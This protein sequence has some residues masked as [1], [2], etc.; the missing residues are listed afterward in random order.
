MKKNVLSVL[1]VAGIAL[2]A[3]AQ[4]RHD[5]AVY[6]KPPENKFWKHIKSSLDSFHN[7]KAQQE[8]KALQM[9]YSGVDIPKSINEFKIIEAAQ[10]VSQGVTGTCWCF[11]TTSFFDSEVYRLYHKRVQLSPLYT[12]YW[13][14]VEKAREYVKTRGASLFDEGSETNAVQ[15]MMKKYGIVT[16]QDYSGLQSGQPYQD[17]SKMV[18]EMKSYLASIKTQNAWNEEDVITT[19]E[20]IM[21]HY[22]GIPPATVN[23]DGKQYTPQQYLNEVVQ[24]HPDDYVTLMSLKSAP[25][26]TKAEY[27]VPDNWWH[28]ANYYN[29]PLDAFVNTV[30]EAVKNGYSVSI[31]GDVSESGIN[32]FNGAMMIPTYD[33]PA[34]YINDDARLLRFLNGATTDDHAMHIV[35]YCEKKSG[36]WFLVKDSGAGGFN[37]TVSPGY[38][39]MHEDYLKLKMMTATMHKDAAKDILGKVK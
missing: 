7:P 25:Y 13:Q 10:P 34:A 28:S 6:Q 35:G 15:E 11:S 18:G 4:E 24:L 38:R 29:V 26:W 33:I 8:K 20:S 32:S 14:Y 16:L 39:Y 30:K 3:F 1:L 2:T 36:T 31:G 27:K 5:K 17:H 23:E 37:N 12:V 22:M 9:D 21:N 19:I